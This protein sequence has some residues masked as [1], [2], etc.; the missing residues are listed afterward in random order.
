MMLYE[1][2]RLRGLSTK[3]KSECVTGSSAAASSNKGAAKCTVGSA[4]NISNRCNSGLANT[5][6]HDICVNNGTNTS[7][8]AND[9][10]NGN[11]VSAASKNCVAG[12]AAN[13]NIN[14]GVGTGV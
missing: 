4:F 8:F 12:T 11:G 1:K 3:L 13:S 10:S 7:A 9:C 6:W 5:D 14:C 2:P